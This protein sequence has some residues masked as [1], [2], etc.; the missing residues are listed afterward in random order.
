[1]PHKR[2]FTVHVSVMVFFSGEM[3]VLVKENI[4]LKEEVEQHLIKIE[5]M[6]REIDI[7]RSEE[8]Q[9]KKQ[10]DEALRQ[11]IVCLNCSSAFNPF[12]RMEL[13]TRREV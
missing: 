1:M 7:A 8:A 2:S 12:V 13:Y 4:Q 3:E 11:V 5:E 9:M 10:L 6:K